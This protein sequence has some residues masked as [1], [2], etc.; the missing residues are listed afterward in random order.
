ML[1][2]DDLQMR[3]LDA[4]EAARLAEQIRRLSADGSAMERWRRVGSAALRPDHPFEVH[5]YVRDQIYRDWDHRQGPIPL[6]VPSPELLAESNIG[7]VL[8][9]RG[10]PDYPSLHGWSMADP[11]GF[12]SFTLT[13]LG[14]RFRQQPSRI[15]APKSDP[16]R[17]EWL[18]GARLNICESCFQS[19]EDAPAIV[20]GWGAGT[21]TGQ[22]YGQLRE[23][24]NRVSNSLMRC[25][26]A[27][28]DAIAIVLNM[29]LES[30]AIYLGIVQAGCVVVSIAESFAP[31]E[32]RRRLERSTSPA[33][34]T[35]TS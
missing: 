13:Q 14:I 19:P 20:Y 18:P 35:V 23:L 2:P 22:S 4:P 12:W 11:E 16:R 26:F 3:G 28:G 1:R 27:P 21:I 25:G 17:P 32:I 15:L 31:P 24:T 34:A 33:P 6:W 30:V 10:L 5:R 29:R 7:K 8:R 9:Q